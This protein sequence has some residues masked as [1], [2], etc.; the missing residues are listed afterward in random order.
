MLHCQ[1]FEQVRLHAD[2]LGLPVLRNISEPHGYRRRR[3]GYRR[4]FVNSTWPHRD[5]PIWPHQWD[6]FAK[7][8]VPDGR[9]GWSPRKLNR[10]WPGPSLSL[11]CLEPCQHGAGFVGVVGRRLVKG[12]RSRGQ[13]PVP[14]RPSTSRCWTL[15]QPK[16]GQA[17]R[18]AM[19]WVPSGARPGVSWASSWS[20]TRSSHQRVAGPSVLG[21]VP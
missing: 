20:A 16:L 2:I 18:C 6:A 21:R 5:R 15:R 19:A 10:L 8:F 4:G 11:P 17:S 1:L 9:F 14:G 13:A 3:L 7:S 12:R